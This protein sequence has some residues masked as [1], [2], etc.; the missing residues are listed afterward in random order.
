MILLLWCTYQTQQEQLLPHVS[1][2]TVAPVDTSPDLLRVQY[3]GPLLGQTVDDVSSP[4]SGMAPSST[5]KGV[6]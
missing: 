1:H 5:M 4:V 6:L 3:A 2:A